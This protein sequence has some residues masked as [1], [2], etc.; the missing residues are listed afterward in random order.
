MRK[1]IHI[2]AGL[3]ICSSAQ[4][5]DIGGA[6]IKDGKIIGAGQELMAYNGTSIVM[7]VSMVYTNVTAN[8]NEFGTIITSNLTVQGASTFRD[9]MDGGGNVASNFSFVGNG[10]GLTNLPVTSSSQSPLTN[11]LNGAGYSITNLNS[12]QVTNGITLGTNTVTGVTNVTILVA[13]NTMTNG[14]VI[15]ATGTNSY[16]WLPT[17]WIRNSYTNDRVIGNMIVDGTTNL[18]DVSS[19]VPDGV[20]T[21]FI[22]TTF[23]NSNA[24]V[25]FSISLTNELNNTAQFVVRTQVA[26]LLTDITQPMIIGTNR[27]LFYRVSGAGT[28]TL[29][30]KI[31]GGLY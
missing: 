8:T 30:V 22:R 17:T 9:N 19:I 10:A 20:N 21:I 14:T 31:N 11:N 29:S 7:V 28:V 2:L 26:N 3:L 18:W 1:I 4:A 23:A 16:A 24:T 15:T 6:N 12:V 25:N 5:I 13:D 27:Q